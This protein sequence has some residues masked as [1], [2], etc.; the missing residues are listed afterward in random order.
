M[1]AFFY[2]NN[3]IDSASTL[4]KDCLKCTT[5]KFLQITAFTSFSCLSTCPDGTY[6]DLVDQI[7]R[8]C[9]I[10]CYSCTGPTNG[11][12]QVCKSTH[13][14]YYLHLGSCLEECPRGFYPFGATCTKCPE[15]CESCKSE[16][17]CVKCS[18]GYVYSSAS[19][20]KCSSIFTGCSK[21][22][23]DSKCTE[24]LSGYGLFSGTCFQCI[25]RNC[26]NCP[27][28]LAQCTKCAENFRFTIIPN[29]NV[30]VR[31]CPEGKLF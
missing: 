28:N 7:C 24:C 21:C 26:Q 23:D 19:C 5:N 30:C 17:Y 25:T 11:E 14:I 3:N 13:K 9:S 27:E 6:K 1:S 15:G 20:K 16:N 22:P 10:E 18:E 2:E 8:P 12:C 31:E 29:A 4:E